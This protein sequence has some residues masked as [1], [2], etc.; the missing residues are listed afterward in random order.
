MVSLICCES[1]EKWPF[2]G[3]T[4]IKKQTIVSVLSQ[5]ALVVCTGCIWLGRCWICVD[6]IWTDQFG[7]LAGPLQSKLGP[8]GV[9][10]WPKLGQQWLVGGPNQPWWFNLVGS[11]WIEV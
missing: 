6:N 7:P 10:K 2:F 1:A 3:V 8:K 11:G 4:S 5:S 9:L